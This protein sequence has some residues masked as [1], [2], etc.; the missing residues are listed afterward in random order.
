MTCSPIHTFVFPSSIRVGHVNYT[1]F[2]R[3]RC[4]VHR[5]LQHH[6]TRLGQRA[7]RFILSTIWPRRHGS[8]LRNLKNHEAKK[9]LKTHEAKT[10]TLVA[11]ELHNR[12]TECQIDSRSNQIILFLKQ[13][14][15]FGLNRVKPFV[16]L[17]QRLLVLLNLLLKFRV[18]AHGGF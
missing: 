5:S 9:S 6:R 2:N 15:L 18:D 8:S 16:F 17:H 3:E 12:E 7:E 14:L 1:L 4:L 13:C 10:H 11:T